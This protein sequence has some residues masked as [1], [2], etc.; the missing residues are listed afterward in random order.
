MYTEDVTFRST[1][2]AMLAGRFATIATSFGLAP[3]PISTSISA[4]TSP[5]SPNPNVTRKPWASSAVEAISWIQ[6]P[7]VASDPA[8]ATATPPLAPLTPASITCAPA[9]NGQIPN[10]ITSYTALLD[11]HSWQYSDCPGDRLSRYERSARSV[12]DHRQVCPQ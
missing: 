3:M 9:E 10:V 8:V 1:A 2:V 5:V 4:P 11:G 12:N 6:L 7:L